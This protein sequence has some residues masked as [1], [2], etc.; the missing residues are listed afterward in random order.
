LIIAVMTLG[1]VTT[2]N[3]QAKWNVTISNIWKDFVP[4]QLRGCIIKGNINSQG[5]H[6]YHTSES[7]YYH[8]TTIKTSNGKR[9]FCSVSEAEAAGWRAPYP[10]PAHAFK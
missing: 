7:P 5:D 9:W 1:N 2:D 8:D 10:A 3:L 6:I 4:P